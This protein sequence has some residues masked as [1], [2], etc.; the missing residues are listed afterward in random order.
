MK[1]GFDDKL[2]TQFFPDGEVMKNKRVN[3]VNKG[4]SKSIQSWVAAPEAQPDSG[5]NLMCIFYQDGSEK[6]KTKQP[7]STSFK[8]VRSVRFLKIK[9]V[10]KV[11]IRGELLSVCRNIG[12]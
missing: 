1:M 7:F 3:K 10:C 6:V 8:L 5:T 9:G 4:V 11:R 12:L 2:S